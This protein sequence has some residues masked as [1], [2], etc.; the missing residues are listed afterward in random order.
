MSADSIVIP[1]TL[2]N[3]ASGQHNSMNR[4][5]DCGHLIVFFPVRGLFC[6]SEKSYW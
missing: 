5:P 6:V 4:A 2:H 3:I 1:A